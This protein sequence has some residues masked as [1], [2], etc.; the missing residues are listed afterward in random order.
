L[1]KNLH[2]IG[3]LLLGLFSISTIHAQYD[4]MS[5]VGDA[6]PAGWAANGAG[7]KQSFFQSI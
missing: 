7:F 1:R 4:Y 2:L 3:L 5:I 6:T